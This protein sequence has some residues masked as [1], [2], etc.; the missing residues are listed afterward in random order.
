[1]VAVTTPPDAAANPAAAART[2]RFTAPGG[3]RVI[4]TLNPDLQL[5]VRGGKS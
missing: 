2:V 1:M 5:T 4:W 3:T